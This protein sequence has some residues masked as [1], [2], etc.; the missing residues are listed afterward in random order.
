MTHAVLSG[1]HVGVSYARWAGQTGNLLQRDHHSVVCSP[2]FCPALRKQELLRE[3]LKS[4]RKPDGT[5]FNEDL[6]PWPDLADDSDIFSQRRR[7]TG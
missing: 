2:L 1:R 6:A 5:P 4:V 7:L 3:T